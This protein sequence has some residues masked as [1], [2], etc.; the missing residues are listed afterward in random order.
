MTLVILGIDALDAQLVEYWNADAMQLDAYGAM[1]TYAH[2]NEQPMTLE[3]WPTVA[4]GEHSRQ[5]G[6]G[7]KSNWDNSIVEVASNLLG[8]RLTNPVR[9]KLGRIIRRTTGADF[10]LGAVDSDTIFDGDHRY[11]H[12]WP[13]TYNPTELQKVWRYI[14]RTTDEAGVPE[15]EWDAEL[16]ANAAQKF[17]WVRERLRHRATLVATHVHVLDAG[18]HAYYNN[19]P[20]YR[21]FYDRCGEYIDDVRAAMAPEDDLLILSDHGTRTGWTDPDAEGLAGHSWRAFSASTTGDRPRSVF[22]VY[23]WVEA[24]IREHGVDVSVETEQTVDTPEDVLRTLG[25]ID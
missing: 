16:W 23:D 5:H 10:E 7:S 21:E 2:Y 11:V 15:S 13:G 14:D 19:E 20:H 12:N 22:E 4:T 3:V 9:A 17:G 18:G 25:Y 6:T 24:Y 8:P 1:D